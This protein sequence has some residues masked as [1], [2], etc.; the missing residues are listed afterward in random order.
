MGGTRAHDVLRLGTGE[1]S[2]YYTGGCEHGPVDAGGY[3]DDTGGCK[4]EEGVTGGAAGGPPD[5]GVS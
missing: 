1:P 3:G 2:I 5:G 4:L